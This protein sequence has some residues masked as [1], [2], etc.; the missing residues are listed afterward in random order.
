MFREI[1]RRC[2]GLSAD[3]IDMPKGKLS[4]ICSR[5]EKGEGFCFGREAEETHCSYISFSKSCALPL[6]RYS[7]RARKNHQEN[8]MPEVLDVPID[9]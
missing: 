1:Q 5:G 8:S 9:A 7:T 6:W 3:C 4:L 2:D